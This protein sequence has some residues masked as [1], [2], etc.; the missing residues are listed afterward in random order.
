MIKINK[1]KLRCPEC[2]SNMHP[3]LNLNGGDSEFWMQCENC[4]TYIDTYIPMPHQAIM[5]E[6]PARYVEVAGGYGTGKTLFDV[7]DKEKHMLITKNGRT[8]FGAPTMPQLRPTLK[9][10]FEDDFPIDFVD[11]VSKNENSVRLIN[12]HEL[13]YRSFDDPHKL[14]SLNLSSF[15]I[16]EGSGSKHSVFTQLQNRLRNKAATIVQLDEHGDE[17]WDENEN[18]EWAPV[19]VADWRKGT[20]ETNPD[21]GWVKSEFLECS[22]RVYLHD[23]ML[24]EEKYNYHDINPAMSTHIAPTK[25]NYNLPANYIEEQSKGKPAWWVKR[26]FHGSFSYAEGLVYPSFADTIV[27]AFKIPKNWKRIIAMDYGINDNTHFVFGALDKINHIMYIYQE[28]VISDSNI[29]TIATEYKKLLRA[30]PIG[31]L[32]TTPVMDQRSMSKRQS[33]D[34]KTLGTLFEDEGL[35]FD[36]AQMSIDARVLRLNTLIELGQLKVF[37]TCTGLIKEALDYRFPEKVLGKPNKDTDKPQDKFNHGINA[38]EFLG[39]ELPHNLELYDFTLYNK[40]G[41]PIRAR[42]DVEGLPQ[43]PKTFD[44]F[45]DSKTNDFNIHFGGDI[46]G[47][48]N[49]NTDHLFDFYIPDDMDI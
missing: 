30:I 49:D 47:S 48:D 38:L 28:L 39:M 35:L 5:H 27:P 25:V 1:E 29:K 40:S 36:P 18:G 20:I 2:G 8:L 46:N 43:R 15:V 17:V 9:K 42:L 16:L 3:S 22:G 11:K 33:L 7:K 31:A 6:D 4:P 32:L 24:F 45:K 34:L 13:L 37:N 41:K 26:Y 10:D 23:K 19:Y 12:G 14:R 21:P 44:P